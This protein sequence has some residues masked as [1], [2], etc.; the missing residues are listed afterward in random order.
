MFDVDAVAA[1]LRAAGAPPVAVRRSDCPDLEDDE[2]EL[3]DPF[4][5]QVGSCYL[6]LVRENPGGTYTFFPPV[7]TVERIIEQFQES[8]RPGVQPV[9]QPERPP[10]TVNQQ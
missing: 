10:L 7:T 3:A 5:V 1:A 4:H 8:H 6:I 2:V 9:R